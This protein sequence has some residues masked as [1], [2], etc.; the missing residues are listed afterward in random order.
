[1]AVGRNRLPGEEDEVHDVGGDNG[2]IVGRGEFELGLV[3]GLTPADFMRTDRVYSSVA[4]QA[5]DLRGQILVEVDLHSTETKRT[6]PGNS[7]SMAS[8]VSLAF[9]S[10]CRWISSG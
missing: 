10:T 2:S 3:A 7:F 6:S 1:M 5:R 8:G 4:E 9:A